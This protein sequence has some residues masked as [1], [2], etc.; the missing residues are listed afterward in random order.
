[1]PASPVPRRT[2][3]E[4]TLAAACWGS[5]TVVSKAAI[6]EIAPLTLLPVQLAASLA[7]L[8]A[9]MLWRGLPLRDRSAS[10]I[11]G[12]LGLLNPGLAYALSLLGLAYVTASLSVMLWAIE[13]LLILVLAGWFLHE[14]IGP[15]LVVFS[16]V[17]VAGIALVI[18]QP[19]GTGSPLGV[20]L[21]VA[22]VGCCAAYTVITR[23]WLATADSTTQVVAAQEVY[24][25]AFALVLVGVAW[26]FGGAVLPG[27]ISLTAWV[28]A[29]VSGVLYYGLAYWFYLSALRDV[30]ASLAA[31][32][33]YLIPVFG[34]AGGFLLLGERLEP[35]QWIG[36][37]TVL[38]AMYL[39]LRRT[40]RTSPEP[41]QGSV[42]ASS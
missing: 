26:V 32:S 3:L 9:L 30:P 29:I 19:G 13:P 22:G 17:A 8:V 36:V 21:T 11:L 16:L 38:I 10:P 35:S 37:A 18:Y 20:L 7:L 15:S 23:R 34:V 25:L 33:F 6:A 12:R 27:N 41:A 40:S 4:L 31:V 1:M 14:R 39:I 28:S 42:V 2:V 24:A 5:G